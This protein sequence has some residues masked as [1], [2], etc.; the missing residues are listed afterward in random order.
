MVTVHQ[1]RDK[2]LLQPDSGSRNR[3]GEAVG[4]SREVLPTGFPQK[5]VPTDNSQ[6]S[7]V[8]TVCGVVIQRYQEHSKGSRPERKM[9][10]V[11]LDAF[12]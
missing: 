2:D 4:Q 8:A 3:E 5:R 12:I 7:H 1:M 10:S 11:T 6:T 9:R